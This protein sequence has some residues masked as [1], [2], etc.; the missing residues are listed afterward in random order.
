MQ[1]QIMASTQVL[2]N[3][4]SVTERI[5]NT[6][7]AYQSFGHGGNRGRLQHHGRGGTRGRFQHHGRGDNADHSHMSEN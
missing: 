1:Q 4:I 7:G 3:L 2:N 5:L 6:G